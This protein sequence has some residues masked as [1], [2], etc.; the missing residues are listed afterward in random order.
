MS[1]LKTFQYRVL[2]FVLLGSSL[3]SLAQTSAFSYQGRLQ[4]GGTPANGSY[5]FQ[6]QLF[7]A[8]SGGNQVGSTQLRNGV[9]VLLLPV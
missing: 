6:F 2:S 7:D 3:T 8:S 1:Y 5:D 9:A 4:D